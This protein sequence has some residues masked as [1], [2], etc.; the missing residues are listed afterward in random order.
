MSGPREAVAKGQYTHG[1]G[2]RLYVQAIMDS[3][4]ILVGKDKE[5]KVAVALDGAN[6]LKR[7]DGPVV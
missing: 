1:P 3:E 4:D 6:N 2:R 7:Y 5:G